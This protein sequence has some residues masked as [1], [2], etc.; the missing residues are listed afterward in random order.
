MR[1]A[2]GRRGR[3]VLRQFAWSNVLL[4]F[5]FD[6]TLA[7]IVRDPERAKM[8]AT[9]RE[10]LAQVARQYPCVVISGRAR[11]DARRRL[12]DVGTLEVIGNHG[13]EPWQASRR[14][15]GAVRRWKPVLERSLAPLQGVT[16]EDKTYSLAI[17]YRR[18][19]E[20]TKAL[21]AIQGATAALPSARLIRGKQVV[22]VL[23]PGS[24]HKG[25]A[26][27]RA[28]DRFGCDTALYVGDDDTDEDV[29]ALDQP[30]RLLTVRVGR[31]LDSLALYYLKGQA[32]IDGLLRLLRR[33]GAERRTVAHAR[34]RR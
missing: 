8:R 7:P 4:A 11:A 30:G 16:V 32:E 3:E 5:D 1:Y 22:N 15:A 28:R 17:H 21:L 10:L 13:I 12:R 19:R 33:V 6:G 2:L 23:P 20:K 31:S 26:L 25:T 18:S 27:E 24:P 29:F 34:V 14:A 9:T